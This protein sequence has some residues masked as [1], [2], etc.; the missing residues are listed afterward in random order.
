T[1]TGGQDYLSTSGTLSFS[2]GE[3]SKSF[4]I[5]I[6]DD[7]ATEPDETFT[8]ELRNPPSLEALGAPSNLVVTIQ[9]RTTVPVIGQSFVSVVE[10]DSGTTTEALLTFNLSAA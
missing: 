10:G 5:P 9:D 3:T 4:Q 7:A 6:A 2:G 8:V 1:A